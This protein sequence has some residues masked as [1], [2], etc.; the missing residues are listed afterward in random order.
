MRILIAEDEELVANMLKKTLEDQGYSIDLAENGEVA[1]E[2][3]KKNSYAIVLTDIRMPK[4][5]GLELLKKIKNT[6]KGKIVDVILITGYSD[7]KYSMDALKKG[8]YDYF[9]KPVSRDELL[10]TIKRVENK[11]DIFDGEKASE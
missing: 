7:I 10:S 2:K 1:F 4:M 8:A 9:K 6:E 5:D 3:F 11:R